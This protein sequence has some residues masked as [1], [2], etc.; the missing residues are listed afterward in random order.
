MP[1]LVAMMRTGERSLSKA[2][3]KKEKHSMSNMWT[4]S[5]K[6]TCVGEKK[7]RWS[8]AWWYRK[9]I[10]VWCDPMQ[11]GVTTFFF[12]LHDMVF[13]AIK[14][15]GHLTNKYNFPC[16]IFL[17]IYLFDIF[18]YL[19]ECNT[20]SSVL[21]KERHFSDGRTPPSVFPTLQLMQIR[22]SNDFYSCSWHDMK[23][24]VKHP[25]F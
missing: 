3:F 4:S 16:K 10:T 8:G 25:L 9:V 11:S 20:P 15:P 6:R 7:W 14:K 12:F 5:I 22:K 23:A 19:N 17:N 13:N 1:R 18:I 2:R 21:L 24:T